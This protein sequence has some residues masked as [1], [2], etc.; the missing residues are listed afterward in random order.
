MNDK[1]QNV[2]AK[3]SLRQDGATQPLNV[4]NASVNVEAAMTSSE[5]SEIAKSAI[6]DAGT[7]QGGVGQVQA[8]DDGSTGDDDQTR[9][10]RDALRERL[11][12]QA[13]SEPVMRSEVRKKLVEK[14]ESLEN[15]VKKYKA[16]RNHH[17]SS[18]AIMKLRLVLR[19]LEDLAST[20]YE[21]LK[22]LWLNVV[23]NFA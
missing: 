3:E 4:T 15:E 21:A 13:P 12:M 11:L 9:E 2:E 17:A 19:Q 14:R 7:A 5:V 10:G 18:I 6:E 1:D 23:H 20:T 8:Q 16:K 22:S